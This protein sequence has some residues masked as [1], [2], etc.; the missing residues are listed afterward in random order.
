MKQGSGTGVRWQT[1]VGPIRLDI[2][3]AIT[4]P[5]NPWRIHFNIGPDL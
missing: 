1:P 4:E 2:A 3:W 5:D